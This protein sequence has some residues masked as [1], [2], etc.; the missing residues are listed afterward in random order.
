MPSAAQAVPARGVP[1]LA[2][3]WVTYGAFYFCRTNISAALP[4]IEAEHGFSKADLG[5]VLA[6]F[7]IAYAVGQLV[8]GQLAERISA[9]KLLALGMFGSA[10][11]N[12]L[13]GWGVGVWFWLFVWAANG[14]AQ[15]LGWTPT[16]KVATRWIPPAERGVKL[17][18][19]GTSY[20]VAAAVTFLL[21]GFAADR[22][23]WAA[24][25]WLPALAFAAAGVFMLVF[26]RDAPSEGPS[27]RPN[28][29]P[30]EA[31]PAARAETVPEAPM[32]LRTTIVRTIGNPALWL[33]ALSLGLLNATRYGFLD[34]GLSHVKEMQASGVGAA[35]AKYAILPIGGIF[36]ALLSGWA[37][38]RFSAGRR[39]PVVIGLLVLLSALTI[40]YQATVGIGTVAVVFTLLFVGFAIFGAQVLLVG[41]FPID[42]A[43][44]GTAAASV[45]FVNCMGY[46]GAAVG[47]VLTGALVEA[48]GWR[49]A[50]YGWA[51]YAL[52]A[53]VLLLPIRHLGAAT[54]PGT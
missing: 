2:V 7:K 4:G 34:W 13:F 39:A 33:L 47:D 43:R 48:Y 35:A 20:Q 41:A 11:L 3:L 38:D 50:V 5:W 31:E 42:L 22:F 15:A 37:S 54:R 36:G 23:G 17:G 9:R 45:G 32:P 6:S 26:L 53:A 27:V 24:A 28:E 18:V 44:P 51:A 30:R 40:L 14:Y 1:M 12:V 46:V 29:R 16:M 52:L 49:T 19:L 8:N 25:M 10:A 21:A